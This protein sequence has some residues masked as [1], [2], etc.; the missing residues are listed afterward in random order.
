IIA[1][2][3]KETRRR[4][5]QTL[6]E[7]KEDRRKAERRVQ[8]LTEKVAKVASNGATGNGA[9]DALADLHD[10]LREMEQRV[11]EIDDELVRGQRRLI[12]EDELVG[13]IEAFDPIWDTLKQSERERMIRLLVR[14]VEYD[15]E[16]ET[17]TVAFH[18][19]GIREIAGEEAVK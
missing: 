19:N 15:A 1:E 17:V 14:Q 12:D 8:R 6:D 2:A 10:R 7:L 9:A 4:L 16:E 3:I 11:T 18:P 5:E 13:A